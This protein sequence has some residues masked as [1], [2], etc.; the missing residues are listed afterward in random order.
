MGD[1]LR[2]MRANPDNPDFSYRF[3]RALW[4]NGFIGPLANGRDALRYERLGLDDLAQREFTAC[5][6]SDEAASLCLDRAIAQADPDTKPGLE[7]LRQQRFT[8][9]RRLDAHLGPVELLGT[10][11]VAPTVSRSATVPF[12]LFW[13]CRRPLDREYAVFVHFTGPG[14]FQS[15]HPPAGGRLPT[16]RWVPGE[17]IRDQFVVAIP[18]DAPPG[19][20]TAHVGFWDPRRRSR[21]RSGWFGA[22]EVEAFSFRVAE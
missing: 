19:V 10:G 13:E 18:N 2:A 7:A 21:L 17:T 9:D 15:D 3:A 4:M 11:T 1:Y 8:P 20:Y 12:E 5:A 14:R 6:R 22:S 16:P